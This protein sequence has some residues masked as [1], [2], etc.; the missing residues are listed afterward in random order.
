[1]EGIF[2][3]LAIQATILK[4]LKV[5]PIELSRTYFGVNM[6]RTMLSAFKGWMDLSR[7]FTQE[8]C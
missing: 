2:K 4:I 6:F 5:N 8:Q 1:M 7:T 3:V